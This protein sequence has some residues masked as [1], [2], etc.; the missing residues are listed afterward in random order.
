MLEWNIAMLGQLRAGYLASCWSST[1]EGA[2]DVSLFHTRF[3]FSPSHLPLVVVVACVF[4]FC[5][6]FVSLCFASAWGVFC[7]FLRE[8]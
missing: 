6:C 7:S 1:Y 3:T 5:L 4:G 8:F 2:S